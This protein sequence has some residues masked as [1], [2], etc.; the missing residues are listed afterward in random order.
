MARRLVHIAVLLTVTLAWVG[1]VRGADEAPLP[2]E[3]APG[4]ELASPTEAVAPSAPDAADTKL[5]EVLAELKRQ[6]EE[7]AALKAQNEEFAARFAEAEE[8]ELAELESA[9]SQEVD[10]R[11]LIYGFFDLTL[12]FYDTYEG[13]SSDGLFVD[14]LSFTINR[15]NLFFASQMTESLSVL[16]EI[17]FTFLPLGDETQFAEPLFLGTEYER[18]DTQVRD[19]FSQEIFHLGGVVIDRLHLTW[20]PFDFFNVM[21]GR[22]LT[23]WGIW[24]VEH[25]SPVVI[26]TRHPYLMYQGAIPLAQTGVQIYGRVFP[27]TG[28]HID[29]AVSASNGRGPTEA[30]YDLK[31][32]K[33]LGFKLK[34]TYENSD[35]LASLGGY[36]YWGTTRDVTP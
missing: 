2:P 29:Y 32:Q 33:A 27:A 18:T 23:P 34:F 11:F 15:L 1:P 36:F 4:G 14:S 8:A 30:V 3:P 25:G 12:F 35:V 20:S 19:A 10:K 26:P 5:D 22:F 17:R 13:E 9:E 21:A 31:H 6:Q 24:N 28:F 16:A 7:I